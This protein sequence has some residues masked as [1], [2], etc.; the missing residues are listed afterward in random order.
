MKSSDAVRIWEVIEN[1]LV[2]QCQ[3]KIQEKI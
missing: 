2:A 1:D 3:G